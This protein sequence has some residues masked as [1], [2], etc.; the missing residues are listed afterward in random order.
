MQVYKHKTTI[1][2]RYI[3]A[4][5]NP[6]LANIGDICKS[7]LTILG[8]YLKMCK[9]V[10]GRNSIL[11]KKI[12]APFSITLET[13]IRPIDMKNALDWMRKLWFAVQQDNHK[14]ALILVGINPQ[15]LNSRLTYPIL[16]STMVNWPKIKKDTKLSTE[17]KKIDPM[18]IVRIKIIHHLSRARWWTF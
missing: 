11:V 6:S 5:P 17:L 1:R 12:D 8:F 14:D 10:I 4:K 2:L 16:I 15:K 18:L 7:I 9:I 3:G 13:T